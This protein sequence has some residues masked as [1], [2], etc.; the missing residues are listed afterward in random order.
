MADNSTTRP[1][2]KV[3]DNIQYPNLEA[4]PTTPLSDHQKEWPTTPN[5]QTWR[6]D[7]QLHYQATRR[8]GRQLPIPKPEGVTD[9]S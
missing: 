4:W 8:S 1:P 9:N 2:E 7:R 3:A 5:I 6:H